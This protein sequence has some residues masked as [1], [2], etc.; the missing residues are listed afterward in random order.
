MPDD[1]RATGPRE[2][3]KRPR[4]RRRAVGGTAPTGEGAVT[5]PATGE[6]RSADDADVGWGE[7]PEGRDDDERFLRDV[8]PHW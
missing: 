8:P 6:T 7:R 3:G 5:D 2:P 1:A 4:R